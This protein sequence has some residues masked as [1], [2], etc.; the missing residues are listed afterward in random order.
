VAE[1]PHIELTFPGGCP[2]CGRRLIRLPYPLPEIGDDFDWT[3]RNFDGFRQFMLEELAAAFP[4]RSRWTVA[5]MEVV[6][7]EAL[8]AALDQLSDMA[9]RVNAEA[10]LETA[11]QP[12]SVRRLLGFIGYDAARE[13]GFED[14]AEDVENGRTAEEKFDADPLAVEKARLLGPRS[15]FTQ[16]RMVSVEDYANR[17]QEHPLVLRANAWSR[18]TGSWTTLHIAMIGWENAELDGI[19]EGETVMVYPA[20]LIA[21]IESFHKLHD[22]YLPDLEQSPPPT[23]RTV[24]RPYLEAYRMA[25]QEVVL[26][27]AEYVGIV[28][29][30]SIQVASNYYQSE[31]A[32]E[33]EHA[34]GREP[35]GFFEPGRLKFGEDIYIS[36]IIQQLMQIDGIEHICLNRFKRVGSQFPDRVQDDFIPLDGLEI[37]VCDNEPGKAERGYFYLKLSGGRKG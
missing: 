24:L 12:Q 7:I 37:A 5:D 19:C 32:R 31:I 18:W 6:L 26:R 13:L 10:F 21:Q 34:L 15:V 1:T 16:R 27:D 2:D 28:M 36:D 30:L 20:E 9:D 17:L 11:R 33:V 8:A 25:G 14:D 23:I 35:G 22:L 3:A 29:S 4:E